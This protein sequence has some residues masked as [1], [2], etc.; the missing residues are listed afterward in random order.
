MIITV[1]KNRMSLLV[2]LLL[3]RERAHN[4]SIIHVINRKSEFIKN[5]PTSSLF[6]DFVSSY[7]LYGKYDTLSALGRM[8]NQ[9]QNDQIRERNRLK[10]RRFREDPANS[11]KENER[12]TRMRKEQVHGFSS[13]KKMLRGTVIKMKTDK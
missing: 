4:K 11:Q 10:K 13:E 8:E 7:D 12:Q 3:N 9:Q 1:E 6:N 2:T 5:I